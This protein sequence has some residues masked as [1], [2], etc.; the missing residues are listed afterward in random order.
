[1]QNRWR[2]N[3]LVVA[4][5]FL[6][7]AVYS[8]GQD[9]ACRVPA[10]RGYS[11]MIYDSESRNVYLFGGYSTFSFDQMDIQD[12]WA[13]DTENRTW[14]L[15]GPHEVH[16]FDALAFDTQSRKVIFYNT[17][18][19][20]PEGVQTWAYDLDTNTWQNMEPSTQPP[21]RWGSRMAY[22]AESDV[23]V[24]FGGTDLNT[25]EELAD[26]WTYDYESNTWTKMEPAQSPPPHHF[27]DMVYH[28][29]GDRIVLFGGY[30]ASLA[31][32]L[33]DT[34]TYDANSNQWTQLFPA[35]SPA[36]RSYMALAYESKSQRI[37]MFGGTQ[38]PTNW[39]YEPTYDETWIFDLDTVSWTQALPKKAGPAR[40]WHQMVGTGNSVLLFGGGPSRFEYNSDT[41]AYG[42]RANLWK[43]VNPCADDD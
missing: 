40:A 24:L 25:F 1:M 17:F 14:R 27:P 33:N 21:L 2:I 29:A 31:A 20:T 4:I 11:R 41:Y 34:W 38:D 10:A 22:D 39:P 15:V 7:V 18:V 43:Q 26:T 6:T 5:C 19:F 28:E 42:A 13:F 23:V 32:Y 3:K 12:V 36:P 35:A 9:E 8:S 30:D 16:D 37:V